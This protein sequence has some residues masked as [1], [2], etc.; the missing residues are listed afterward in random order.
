MLLKLAN[1]GAHKNLEE[2]VVSSERYQRKI[3]WKQ[4]VEQLASQFK[5]TIILHRAINMRDSAKSGKKSVKRIEELEFQRSIL[6]PKEYR[7]QDIPEYFGSS[8]KSVGKLM[9]FRR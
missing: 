9:S 4:S 7:E 1:T 3:T 8:C 6:I 5:D 2:V